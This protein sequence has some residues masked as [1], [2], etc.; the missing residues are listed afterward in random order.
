MERIVCPGFRAAGAAANIK[1]EGVLDLGLIFSERPAKA[2]AVFTRNLVK[3]APVLLDRQRID[4]GTARAVIVNS[5]NAN[6]CNGDR[7]MRDAELMA[8][9]TAAELGISPEEV[10]VASTGVIG[11]PMPMERL[12]AAIPGLAQSLAPEGFSDLALAMMTTD[13]VPKLVSQTGRF[14]G[15]VFHLTAAAKGA[16]MIRPDMATMLCF[17]CTDIDAD[18]DYLSYALYTAC[19]RSFNR[20]TIDGDTSTNDTAIILAN[21]ESGAAIENSVHKAVFQRV[22]DD[23]LLTLAKMMVKDGE[24]ATKFVEIKVLGAKNDNDA[25]AVAS[26]IANSN[27]VKTAFFGED[28]NW[29]RILAAAGRAGV[30]LDPHSI[31]VYFDDIA[32]C[33]DGMGQGIDAEQRATKVMKKDEYT[34]TVDLKIGNGEASVFTCDFSYDYVKINADYRS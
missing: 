33:A 27:L 2:G 4:S 7:G 3:A 22:L 1:K 11:A 8:E 31:D 21:G 25:Y 26:T 5:G 34:V 15:K 24:G 12:R 28:A 32:M 23:V 14:N 9:L 29:G 19:E 13:T 30:E 17:I 18:A 16:G 20:I 10:L 6:C